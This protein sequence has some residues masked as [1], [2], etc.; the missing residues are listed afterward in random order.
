MLNNYNKSITYFELAIKYDNKNSKYYSSLANAYYEKKLYS[1]AEKYYKSAIELDPS[2][3]EAQY[4]L[5]LIKN[6]N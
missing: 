6:F 4:N 3:I 5:T 1:Q 2:N